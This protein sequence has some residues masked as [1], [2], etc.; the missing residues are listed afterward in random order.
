MNGSRDESMRGRTSK[1]R[2]VLICGEG[3]TGAL[4]GSALL[5]GG[6]GCMEGSER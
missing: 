6:V 3:K 5:K 1:V 2:T 4:R